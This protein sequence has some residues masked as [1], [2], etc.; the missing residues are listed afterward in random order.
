[1]L[2]ELSTRNHFKT[3]KLQPVD[4]EKRIEES[5]VQLLTYQFVNSSSKEETKQILQKPEECSLVEALQTLDTCILTYKTKNKRKT[6]T[7]PNL[8]QPILTREFSMYAK[9]IPNLHREDYLKLLQ[10][11]RERFKETDV[12]LT[13][14]RFKILESITHPDVI[15][16]IKQKILSE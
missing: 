4:V 3:F 7:K 9:T 10:N 12:S 14:N 5:L 2:F 11:Q 1:M 16:L 15:N 6:T 8:I 13:S